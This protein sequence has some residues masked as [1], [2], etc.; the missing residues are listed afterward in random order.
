MDYIIKRILSA[1]GTKLH[2]GSPEHFLT[3]SCS[4]LLLL[5]GTSAAKLKQFELCHCSFSF[6]PTSSSAHAQLLSC[7]FQ[8]ERSSLCLK[9]LLSGTW[10]LSSS[11][12]A[13][14]GSKKLT[15]C[16]LAKECH[17]QVPCT[18]NKIRFTIVVFLWRIQTNE[19]RGV[20]CCPSIQ[21]CSY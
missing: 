18:C 16:F 11:H 14:M 17:S 12:E 3:H 5:A 13:A 15:I 1:Y 4:L 19:Q 8:C 21:R 10:R 9:Q 20:D 2:V 6:S 7:P